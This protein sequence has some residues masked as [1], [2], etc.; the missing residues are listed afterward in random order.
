NA[1]G[2]SG[3]LNGT[4]SSS[5]HQTNAA[6]ATSRVTGPATGS[7]AVG[8]ATAAPSVMGYTANVLKNS[9][10]SAAYGNSADNVLNALSTG[11]NMASAQLASYQVNTGAISAIVSRAGMGVAGVTGAP[12][13]AGSSVISGNTISAT[14]MGN[15]S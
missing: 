8:L 3:A 1:R 7:V 11:A 13:I 4:L 2:G 9:V 15:S 6:A 5:N 10:S 14:A 12:T